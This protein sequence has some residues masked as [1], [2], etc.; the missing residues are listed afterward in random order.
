M[1]EWLS[2]L[3]IGIS[4]DIRHSNL[5]VLLLI[6]SLYWSDSVWMIESKNQNVENSMKIWNGLIR[7]WTYWHNWARGTLHNVEP[8]T[9]H[10]TNT[11]CTTTNK[12]SNEQFSGNDD[13]LQWWFGNFCVRLDTS[14][15]E[16]YRSL[17]FFVAW[18]ILFKKW[19]R[20][21]FILIEFSKIQKSIRW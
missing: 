20:V 14:N 4:F 9:N 10:I 7:T 2:R 15:F 19:Y 11:T 12:I 5:N 13:S 17:D 3:I 21:I 16:T 18:K 8:N 6:H 1:E